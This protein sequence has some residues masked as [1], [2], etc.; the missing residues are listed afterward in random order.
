MTLAENKADIPI[1]E[2]NDLSQN[3]TALF[4]LDQACRNWGFFQV[5]GHNIE[6]QLTLSVLE[7]ARQFFALPP[8]QKNLL[9]RTQSNPWGF[10]DQELTKNKRDWKEIFDFG[11]NSS[12]ASRQEKSQWPESLPN[13]KK[14]MYS[15]Y[16][17]FHEIALEILSAISLNLGLEASQLLEE[18]GS[19]HTSFQRINYYPV[20]T[21]TTN[22]LGISSHTDAGAL[23]IL[24]DDRNT[25]LEVFQNNRWYSIIPKPG[26]LLVNIGD[27]LQ[28]WSNDKYLAPVHRV[29]TNNLQERYSMPF[30]LNPSYATNYAPI[31]GQP[32]YKT[33]NWGEFR[34]RRSDGDYSD[35]GKEVQISDYRIER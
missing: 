17:A 20:C 34:A 35:Q 24:L 11:P 27:I 19:D 2:M 3:S 29:Q 4:D 22:H 26:T 23:T 8:S 12:L 1:I 15:L 25:G 30:F 18:F 5:T 33:I 14:T 32:K 7:A 10:Y 31:N 9:L 21:D 13:F 6:P 28:V 16:Q